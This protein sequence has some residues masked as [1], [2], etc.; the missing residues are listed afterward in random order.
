MC[1]EKVN[2]NDKFN[3]MSPTQA[4]LAICIAL[5][6]APCP[7]NWASSDPFAV[8]V[9]HHLADVATAPPAVCITLQHVSIAFGLTRHRAPLVDR[10]II[11]AISLKQAMAHWIV[12]LPKPIAP[13]AL[14]S[15]NLLHR[16]FF[17]T[18]ICY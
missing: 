11:F 1:N 5:P 18:T 17:Q 16:L 14:A 2:N 13:L 15:H 4:S 3:N 10:M 6:H 7:L 9:T 12:A 8:E